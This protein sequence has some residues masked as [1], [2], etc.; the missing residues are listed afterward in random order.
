MRPAKFPISLAFVALIGGCGGKSDRPQ[1]SPVPAKAPVEEPAPQV[2]AEA[3][4]PGVKADG[5]IVSAV[6]WFHGSFDDAL[7]RAK[8][9]D[10]LVFIDVGAYWCPPCH[11]LDEKTFVD[12][13]VGTRLAEKYVALHVDAEKGEGPELVER[14][15]VQAYPTILVLEPSGV[16]RDRITDF[17]E[18]WELLEALARIEKG[19][20][21][22]AGLKERAEATPD[23][24]EAA[25]AYANGL[26]LAAK[27]DE[28]V[29]KLDD[30][31]ARDRGNE[32]GF[33]AKAT[34]DK[35]MFVTYK[36]DRDLQ[37]TV[38][39]YRGLQKKYPKSRQ[40]VTAYRQLG[41]VLNDMGKPDEAVKE[42]EAMVATDPSDVGLKSSFGWFSFRE[43]CRPDAGLAAVRAG[44]EREPDSAELHYLAA[45]LHHLLG[46]D[47]SALAEIE[48]A[49]EL[50]PKKA[51]YRR[52][53]QRFTELAGKTG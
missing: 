1:K 25:Y 52:Q 40:A 31:I 16:E 30:V 34:F 9:E 47:A 22:L 43:K 21:V 53:V 28:A 37:G 50:E 51:Y 20:N 8:A 48:K 32:K 18:A 35:I 6:E 10:R 38:E 45:E 46:D 7:A 5:S 39:A 41:R 3:A 17:L 36:I 19:R 49:S 29:A 11:E 24:L 14:Y 23:D 26:A 33:A 12:P 13:D 2:P 42:L 15:H 27:R 44:I 4:A